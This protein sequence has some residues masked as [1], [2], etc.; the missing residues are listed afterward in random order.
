[1]LSSEESV[2]LAPAPATP[3]RLGVSSTDLLLGLGGLALIGLIHGFGQALPSDRPNP[4]ALASHLY[5]LILT[6]G[7]LW[8]GAALGLRLLRLLGLP[9]EPNA[10]TLV[11]ALGLGLGGLAELVLGL[12]LAH[13]W[14]PALLG[15]VLL[16][17]A[18]AVRADL[19]A[20]R[21]ALP[22]LLRG[23]STE[24]QRRQGDRWLRLVP[25]LA[26]V[27]L[28]LLV[29]R[30]LVPPTG[31]DGLLYQLA[32]P[33]EMLR[34][35]GLVALPELEQANMPFTV[36]LLYLLGLA[37]GSDE[38]P[39]LLHVG[40][41]ALTTLAT[42]AFG[43]R[44][45]GGRVAWLA[46]IVYLST[47]A[48]AVYARL[49][50]VDFGWAT[51]DFLAVY[52]FARWAEQ[53]QARWLVLAGLLAG[54]SLGSKYLGALTATG[55]G[56]ATVW[57]CLRGRIWPQRSLLQ[58]GLA[59][60]LVAGPWYVKNWLW[61][62]SPLYPYLAPGLAQS[63][64]GYFASQMTSGRDPLSLLLLPLRVYFGTAIEASAAIPALALLVIPLYLFLP[65]R[66]L[67]NLLLA[68]AGLHLAVWSQGI[69]TT[70]YLAPI[71]PTLSLV[72][73]YVLD[74]A[75]RGRPD[76]LT[77]QLG[78]L[79]AV[80]TLLLSV[81]TSAIVLVAERPF[82]QWIGSESR[83][84]FLTRSLRD[85]EAVRWVNQHAGEVSRLLVVGDAR[86]FYLEPPVLADQNLDLSQRLVAAGDPAAARALLRS[87]GISHVLVSQ[88]QLGWLV[89]F[90]PEE[91]IR[92]WWTAFEAGRSGYLVSEFS[93][94]VAAV[95]RV[96]DDPI[97]G[98]RR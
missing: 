91:R 67:L 40:F 66:R 8:L 85:Y 89:R 10:E 74:R 24:R 53:R 39:A 98:S 29:A 82:T 80:G 22:G 35:G 42:F 56:L 37:F 3:S 33:R 95:Y 28:A 46:A 71:F 44:Y 86:L 11:L 13:L 9:H 62:G 6:L 2:R 19:Q 48:L 34:Q 72:A 51:F 63:N 54:L 94:E 90:D 20:W 17:V 76:G 32:G 96:A 5:A 92:R 75:G 69:Q 55:L 49:P 77:R 70:R 12:G 87:A 4:L 73:A 97:E 88:G 79:F 81:G 25:L 21:V 16:V 64:S 36:N 59:A 45:F 65:K 31:Y 26:V 18:V 7:L 15:G 60:A 30:A 57:V 41:V 68:L 58:F 23:W 52:A 84:D 38:L 83:D 1:V 93:N 14:H 27:G 50:N 61:L 47:P 78:A 43:R